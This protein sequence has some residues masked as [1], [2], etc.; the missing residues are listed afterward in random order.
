[1]YL[2]HLSANKNWK[3]INIMETKVKDLTV[4]ELQSIITTTDKIAIDDYLEDMHAL[5]SSEYLQSIREA[6]QDYKSG[7]VKNFKDLFDV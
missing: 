7:K 5:S 3:V 4:E 6:R 1:M 2:L